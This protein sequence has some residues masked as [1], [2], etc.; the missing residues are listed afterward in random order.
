MVIFHVLYF[1]VPDFVGMMVEMVAGIDNGGDLIGN[2]R[3]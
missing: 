2:Q 3:L 1:M